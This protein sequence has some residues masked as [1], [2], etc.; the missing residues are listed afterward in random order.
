MNTKA[1]LKLKALESKFEQISKQI[2]HFEV[3]RD[4]KIDE[5]KSTISLDDKIYFL[6]GKQYDIQQEIETLEAKNSAMT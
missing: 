3:M 1:I 6:E 4:K 5:H 2:E